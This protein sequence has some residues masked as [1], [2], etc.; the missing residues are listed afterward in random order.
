MPYSSQLQSRMLLDSNHSPLNHLVKR[1]TKTYLSN[2]IAHRTSYTQ[3]RLEE[4]IM[5]P[6]KIWTNMERTIRILL[7]TLQFTVIFHSLRLYSP[8]ILNSQLLRK[9]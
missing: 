7:T 9:Q 6:S 8:S 5:K 1:E 3:K 4:T 2:Q